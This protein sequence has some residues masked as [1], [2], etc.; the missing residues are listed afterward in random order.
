MEIL[1]LAAR[2]V[3][4]PFL[5]QT[6]LVKIFSDKSGGKRLILMYHGVVKKT[7]FSLS[8][9]HLALTDFEQQI[10]YLSENFEIISLRDIFK[11]YK[12]G[13]DTKPQLAITFDDGYENN[14]TNAFPVL[15]KYH[16]PAT[17]FVVSKILE[18][19]DYI[20]WYDLIDL[21]K[22][23]LNID[24]FKRNANKLPSEKGNMIKNAVSWGDFRKVMKMLDVE[25]KEI[26]I[27]RN[28]NEVK[29]ILSN[30][31]AEYK[32]MLS[33]GQMMEMISSGLIEIGS[34][35]HHHPNLDVLNI[36]EAR[37][38]ITTSKKLL[39]QA[40]NYKVKS[41]AFPDGAYNETIKQLSINE[42]YENLLAV[43]YKTSS[44]EE[45]ENIL[46]RFCISNTTT[47]ESNYY[48]LF[49][50]FRKKGF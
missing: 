35:T 47:S 36:D 1:K 17:I 48:H 33:A 29:E 26:I 32:N 15:K 25:E 50:E 38:E 46:P 5:V 12:E 23:K 24:F 37:N 2:K 20:L 49:N 13:K 21:V 6:G 14:Y 9:N 3:I 18:N 42:G 19:P 28:S 30:V 27:Q 10:K 40:L 16:V 41:I 4:F 11:S 8:V 31:N 43:D 7:D 34:H 39:E 44:D 45:D 22:S